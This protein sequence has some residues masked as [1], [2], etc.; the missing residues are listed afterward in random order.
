VAIGPA[1]LR[2]TAT[3]ATAQAVQLVSLPLLTRLFLPDAFGVYTA[4]LGVAAILAVFAGMRYDA[5]MVLPRRDALA[6]ALGAL[7]CVLGMA[8]GLVVLATGMAAG[9]LFL[10]PA[11]AHLVNVCSVGLALVVPIAAASRVVVGWMSRSSRFGT[12]G[13]LQC[14]AVP[15]TIA[16]QIAFVRAGVDG[17]TALV[18]GQVCGPLLSLIV[19]Q[20]FWPGFWKR[21]ARLLRDHPARVRFAAVRYRSFPRYLIPY[22]LSSTL[23]D[24]LVQF[25][26]GA[27]VGPAAL[28]LFAI[29]T[30]VVG[31]PHS[32]TYA[33]IN[34][35][36]YRHAADGERARTSEYAV[37]LLEL[38]VLLITPPFAFL[39]LTARELTGPL[40]GARWAAAGVYIGILC[41]PNLLMTAC[42][43]LD[44][45]FDVHG[46]QKLALQID[47]GFT[48]ALV[49]AVGVAAA[50]GGPTAAVMAFAAVYTVYMLV[51]VVTVFNANGLDAR[52]LIRP[53]L[54]LT[55]LGAATIAPLAMLQSLHASVIAK[56]LL[57]A[58]SY[59][60]YLAAL[61]R[62]GPVRGH[63]RLLFST[64][65]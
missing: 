15:L 49:A 32:L 25:E 39:A 27:L 10:A 20:R 28:G 41:A 35:V 37:V 46:T 17:V 33:G 56:C 1:I 44:R 47:V 23:R 58:I 62:I 16:L 54:M 14:V 26:F 5:A 50:V 21:M 13:M 65:R 34:P 38:A 12:V 43:W 53:A 24:R 9:Y 59:A 51:W 8:T 36:F 61:T 63:L 55:A 3:T 57:F 48:V 4:F 31:A 18:A 11:S 40:L 2:L 60:L 6:L 52:V 30:R 7:V 42:S 45:L 19:F 64:S 22:G 29:A